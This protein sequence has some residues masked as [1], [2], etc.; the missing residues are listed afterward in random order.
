MPV[1]EPGVR[2]QVSG[3]GDWQQSAS[4]PQVSPCATQAVAQWPAVQ[5]FEQH[6]EACV[7][8]APVVPHA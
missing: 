7:Q 8:V 5:R 2:G 4:A 6:C 1:V 3:E